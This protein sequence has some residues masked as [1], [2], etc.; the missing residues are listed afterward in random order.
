MKEHGMM[1]KSF[2]MPMVM[3]G[4]KWKSRRLG[5]RWKRVKVGELVWMREAWAPC[6][7]V[8]AWNGRKAFYC[9]DGRPPYGG[10]NVTRW[11]PAVHMPRSV[12]RFVG[13]VVG[14]RQEHLQ[15]ITEGTRK[16]RGCVASRVG[17][18]APSSA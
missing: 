4:S 11:T 18:Y 13:E 5:E 12:C 14:V 17:I 10:L 1:M 6:P 8:P 3:D 9:A 16:Q 7:D 15:D 2:L